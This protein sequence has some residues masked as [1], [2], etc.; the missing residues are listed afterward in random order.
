MAANG[1]VWYELVTS[2]LDA[3]QA[4]Y[5]E[6]VGWQAV[7][8]PGGQG[9]YR[10]LNMAGKGIGGL[11]A[12]PEGMT[13]PFW[14]GYVGVADIDAAVAGLEGAGGTVHRRFDIPEVGRI[15]LVADPQGAGLALIQGTS[16]GKS[17]AFDQSKAGHGN[18]HELHSSDWQATWDFYANQFGWAKGIGMDM[19]PMGTYQLFQADGADIGGMM[20]SPDFPRP[21]WLYYFGSENVDAAIERIAAN[22]GTVLH[23]PSEVPGGAWIVQ[24]KD[25]QGAIFALV[26]KRG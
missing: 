16:D 18:W 7:P 26:G 3:A 17:E 13:D 22:G 14:M 24:A 11:M 10:V 25:P 1:F 12:L 9:D 15:A 21:I 6:V 8:F 4:F 20:D 23:G 2:D 19:G 5:G